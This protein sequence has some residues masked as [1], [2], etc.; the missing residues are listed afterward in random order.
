MADIDGDGQLEVVG[1]TSGMHVRAFRRNGKLI[2]LKPGRAT[3]LPNQMCVNANSHRIVSMPPILE[4]PTAGDLNGDGRAEVLV[5]SHTKNWRVRGR[6]IQS[7]PPPVASTDYI[8][9]LRFG[10]VRSPL[11]G[12]PVGI[13]YP[14]GVPAYGPG[15]VAIGD[16]DGDLLPDVVSASGICGRHDYGLGWYNPAAYRCFTVNAYNRFGALLP[17]FPKATPGPGA[18]NAIT[19]AIGDLAGDGLKEIVWIDWYGNIMV[20]DVPGTRAPEAMQWPMFRHDPA[21]T[22]ALVASP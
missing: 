15:P 18:M 22:G 20:W 5:S 13:S 9:A 16:I 3:G 10:G 8:N 2:A 7:C 12:W 1:L 14:S 17:G 21:H 4:P 19:P 11:A 6:W